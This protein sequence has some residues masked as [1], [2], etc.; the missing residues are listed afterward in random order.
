MKDYCNDILYGVYNKIVTSLSHT[1][2]ILL[3]E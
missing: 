2:Y 1:A 3:T